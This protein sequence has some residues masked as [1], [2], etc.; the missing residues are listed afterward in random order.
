MYLASR[1]IL[2]R[3]FVVSLLIAC[4][5]VSAA[6][7]YFCS[8][9]SPRAFSASSGGFSRDSR[10]DRVMQNDQGGARQGHFN[11]CPLC[12]SP[13]LVGTA[14]APMLLFSAQT[15]FQDVPRLVSGVANTIY[16]P[17]RNA[18]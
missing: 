18:S 10:F 3:I 6:D 11:I 15:A 13:L 14:H 8:D 16:K 9:C 7:T 5:F 1:L 2:S 12:L 4:V 17:P